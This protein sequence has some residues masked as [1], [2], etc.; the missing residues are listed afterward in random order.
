MLEQLAFQCKVI[1]I[2]TTFN[3]DGFLRKVKENTVNNFNKKDGEFII[4]KWVLDERQ[5]FAMYVRLLNKNE[6][7]S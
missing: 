7:F 2:K 3:Y 5:L 6:Q 4:K 1:G